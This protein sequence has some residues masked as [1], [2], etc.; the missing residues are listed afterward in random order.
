VIAS[1]IVNQAPTTNVC[2]AYHYLKNKWE[3]VPHTEEMMVE[4]FERRPEKGKHV[5]H[6]KIMPN[7]NWCYF[8][9]VGPRDV[10]QDHEP[11]ADNLARH[12]SHPAGH[13][14]HTHFNWSR[15]NYPFDRSKGYPSTLGPTSNE[16]GLGLDGQPLHKHHHGP[17]C[18]HRASR[19]LH[20][21]HHDKKREPE[22]ATLDGRS[23]LRLRV[24]LESRRKE[25]EGRQFASYEVVVP[26]ITREQ[27]T[28]A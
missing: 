5:R 23:G 20:M 16:K 15:L 24:W 26:D 21:G 9:E 3:P 12:S 25:A 17:F 4:M 6:R 10:L 22:V 28:K 18:H 13:K 14:E 8:E 27:E 11:S 2:I 19:L 7:R 1:A